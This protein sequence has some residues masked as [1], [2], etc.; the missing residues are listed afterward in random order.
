MG[1]MTTAGYQFC[2]RFRQ[3]LAIHNPSVGFIY[4]KPRPQ[5]CEAMQSALVRAL[6]YIDNDRGYTIRDY[7][8]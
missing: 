8:Y 7:R 4:G 1:Q 3:N 5:R 6:H 2:V